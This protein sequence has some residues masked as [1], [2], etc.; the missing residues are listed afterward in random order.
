MRYKFMGKLEH[1]SEKRSGSIVNCSRWSFKRLRAGCLLALIGIVT[2]M[3]HEQIADAESWR[4]QQ[5]ID[6]MGNVVNLSPYGSNR[7]PALH[8]SFQPHY[9]SVGT[10]LHDRVAVEELRS[11]MLQYSSNLLAQQ[12][13]RLSQRMSQSIQT[14]ERSSLFVYV[15]DALTSSSARQVQLTSMLLDSS[16]KKKSSSDAK[17]VTA[18]QNV[19][20]NDDLLA[21]ENSSVLKQV[22][23]T[24][25]G[26][27]AGIESTG[28]EPGHPEYG[29]TYSGVK[30]R[31]DYV[32]TIAADLNEFPIGSILYVPGY[33]YGVVADIGSAI[34]GKKIDL[35]FDTT[36][37]VYDQ[38]GKKVVEVQMIKKGDGKITE[39]ALAELNE[40]VMKQ[41]KIPETML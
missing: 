16:S 17:A 26:Y 41:H 4:G 3:A 38:W 1:T 28:K 30:V 5:S 36:K 7:L 21:P 11:Y 14:A 18:N 22:K 9:Q 32:S 25:T 24:A 37:Q 12:Q 27:T 19:M 13:N 20:F 10:A 2:F 40:A 31:R 35:Y 39:E 15:D 8:H 6:H 29:I 34:K 33:G 23:V